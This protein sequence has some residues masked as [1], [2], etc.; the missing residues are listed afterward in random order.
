MKPKFIIGVLS[1]I[2]LIFTATIMAVS[3]AGGEQGA[4]GTEVSDLSELQ[5]VLDSHGTAVLIS[6]IQGDVIAKDDSVI[7]LNG[8]V[9]DGGIK[10]VRTVTLKDSDPTRAHESLRYVDPIDGVTEHMIQGGAVTGLIELDETQDNFTMEGGT[11]TGN[12]GILIKMGSA[13]MS[14]GAIAGNVGGIGEF[15]HDDGRMIS[16][17]PVFVTG[18]RS[19]FTMTGGT[20]TGNSGKNYYD[21]NDFINNVGNDKYHGGVTVH[22]GATFT[23]ENGSITGNVNGIGGGVLLAYNVTF[24][25]K[26]GEISGNVSGNGAGIF[27]MNSDLNM[28][29][30]VIAY[31]SAVG[32]NGCGG[33]IGGFGSIRWSVKTEDPSGPRVVVPIESNIIITGGEIKGNSAHVDGGGLYVVASYNFQ[34]SGASVTENKAGRDGGGVYLSQLT[35]TLAIG[36]QGGL[37][38]FCQ[39]NA[40][41]KDCVI[42]DNVALGNG[43][44]IWIPEFENP[45]SVDVTGG[46]YT[47]P[48][49]LPQEDVSMSGKVT[50]TGNMSGPIDSRV[51]DDVYLKGDV[52]INV[53]GDLSGSEIGIKTPATPTASE[54]VVF[55]KGLSGKGLATCFF[56]DDATYGVKLNQTNEATLGYFTYDIT[57]DASDHGSVSVSIEDSAVLTGIAAGKLV[58][59]EVAPDRLYELKELTV[60]KD[61][62]DIAITDL[63]GG[64]YTFEMPAADVTVHA[65]FIAKT[66]TVLVAV[67]DEDDGKL[68]AGAEMQ[69]IGAGE[70]VIKSWTSGTEAFSADGLLPETDYIIRE[71]K[72]PEG[73]TAVS[74]TTF[75]INESGTVTTTC[76]TSTADGVTTLFIENPLIR[77]TVSLGTSNGDVE[78]VSGDGSYT[79]NSSVTVTATVSDDRV[80]LGWFDGE[81]KVSDDLSYTFTITGDTTLTAKYREKVVYTLKWLSDDGNVLDTK[82]YL[83][84]ETPP[85]APDIIPTKEEDDANTYTFA[86]W[87]AGAAEGA[88]T[89]FRPT[90]TAVPKRVDPPQTGGN[91]PAALIVLAAAAV[92][93]SLVV[94]GRRAWRKN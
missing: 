64:K 43:G 82:T 4:T 78:V 23:M 39:G 68:K 28:S 55:T 52:L 44:G 73:Y 67:A 83:E 63:G 29:G 32:R 27:I 34:M 12:S 75:S 8:H 50:V 59:L 51:P 93:L 5:S 87:D 86:G 9:L 46:E 11:L 38:L 25:F 31:N 54:P 42:S 70:T 66:Y 49:Y 22:N 21:T 74:D 7:D 72:A 37:C 56:S 33:A 17:G 85:A 24:N 41:F 65:S 77:H 81:T 58:T 35:L 53:T 20:I 60:K 80:F 61:N 89:T 3:G 94:R 48:L 79:P 47:G 84:G 19:H 76:R 57:N 69:L 18:S 40:S 26:G 45:E 62:F 92:A 2:C 10:I 91:A 1:V 15:E 71:T 90:F 14:G 30:G 13:T 6:D 36:G 16:G 88:V